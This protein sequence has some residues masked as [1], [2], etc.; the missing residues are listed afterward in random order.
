ME[1]NRESQNRSI[2]NDR[3]D[4]SNQLEENKGEYLYDYG[5]GKNF[6]QVTKDADLKKNDWYDCIKI[7]NFHL[8]K[9]TVGESKEGVEYIYSAYN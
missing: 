6:E 3:T 9:F 8:S 4:I 1:Q 2:I 7:K 5:V